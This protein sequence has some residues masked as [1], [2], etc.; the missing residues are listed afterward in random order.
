MRHTVKVLPL[1]LVVV[2]MPWV[3]A[4]TP[5]R[6]L[7]QQPFDRITLSAD[8][9]HETIDVTLLD[10]PNRQVPDPLPTSG[11]LELRRVESPSVLYAVD[12]SSIAK[13]ELF[14]QLL[15]AAAKRHTQARDFP[16][17]ADYLE[18]L[19]RNY[20]QLT[21]LPAAMESYLL[22]DAA[23]NFR[24]QRY[25][26]A[27]TILLALY[28][29]NPQRRGLTKM[30]TAVSDRL[31]EK[32]VAEGDFVAA[33]G[34]LQLLAD[35]FPRLKMSSLTT[36]EARLME[37][38]QQQLAAGRDA[39]EQ[40]DWLA[41]RQAIKKAQQILPRIEG[42][43]VLLQDI[44][45]RAPQV[46]VGVGQLATTG[47]RH[48][49]EDW[50]TARVRRLLAPQ[51]VELVNFGA[52]G[53]VYQCLGGEIHSDDGGLSLRVDLDP[54][55]LGMTPEWIARQL[56][57]LSSNASSD[58]QASLACNL[59]AVSI[60]QGKQVLLSWHRP[61]VRPEALLRFPLE[62]KCGQYISAPA[63]PE[64]RH[65]QRRQQAPRDS[66]PQTITEQAFADDTA[67]IKA[68]LD[69]EI[70][71]LDRVAPWHVKTLRQADAL[72][73]D[74]YRLPTLHVLI[75]NHA[76]PLVA[77]REFRRA[78]VYGINRRQILEEI[79]LGGRTR[80]GFQVLSGPL[81]RGVTHSDPI[82]Y[83]Y[84]ASLLPRP[85]EPRLAAALAEAA[86]QGVSQPNSAAAPV[87]PAETEGAATTPL[88]LVH[89]PTT[90]ARTICQ[91]LQVQLSAVDIPLQLEELS[92]TAPP[93]D[94]D[95]L[96]TDLVM[97]EPLVDAR[98]LL[99]PSGT[100][101]SCSAAMNLALHR[102]DQ[103]QN[104]PQLRQRLRRVHQLAAQELPV[105]PLW[106]TVTA[107]A[108]RRTL[109][110]VGRTPVAL[111]QNVTA[112]KFGE[113]QPNP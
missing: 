66:G 111:Y 42:A 13:V 69:G 72:V 76:R 9:G 90:L 55:A 46:V 54:Q 112:W 27:L 65:Y 10:L 102:V 86:R 50:A 52:E 80:A 108:Y 62:S 57:R 34:V 84:D 58:F 4:A 49:L 28:D 79:I 82:G 41:A 39:L 61:V 36:W 93:A 63:S 23:A 51:F 100:A 33:R 31:L 30:V 110:G 59:R 98:R 37:Q 32:H 60:A 75:P 91:T 17:A 44:N 20:P 104:W 24:E 85:Y 78:L 68:L 45:Q 92:P 103:A 106:Q 38:A 67:A 97:W 11:Q 109:Q 48:P 29:R 77:R 105:I 81:P 1:V 14:E 71:V 6:L 95:L 43:D 107:F 5:V 25:E 35:G 2:C 22:R 53:G 64:Q 87:P 12:W 113:A 83:A 74:F 94:Y 8:H 96:Y 15:L 73:V 70:D 26:E 40:G 19:E 47:T 16:Q 88:L 101:G 56:L 3:A 89:P 18:F 99:G 7:D 21:G